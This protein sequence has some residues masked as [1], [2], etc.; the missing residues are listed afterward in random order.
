MA[1]PIEVTP[2]GHVVVGTSV[3]LFA[4]HLGRASTI[5]GAQYIVSANGQRFLMNSVVQDGSQTPI[6]V[7]L[8][9]HPHP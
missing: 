6:R 3:P 9:W 5:F 8:N 4:T 7:I 2:D 1:A